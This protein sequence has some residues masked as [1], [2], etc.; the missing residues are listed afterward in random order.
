[1]QKKLD[2]TEAEKVSLKEA[3]DQQ[4]QKE[5]DRIL[6]IEHERLENEERA[7]RDKEN[8]ERRL[9]GI[10]QCGMNH[11]DGGGAEENGSSS[12]S[13]FDIHNR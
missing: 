8:W 5:E 7:Q 6:R 12:Y 4:I 10:G 9:L 2:Q 11:H 3:L 13:L 1:M